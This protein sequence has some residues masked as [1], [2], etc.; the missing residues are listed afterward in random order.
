MARRKRRHW[1]VDKVILSLAS[2]LGSNESQRF[3]SITC[4][5]PCRTQLST[6]QLFERVLM[7]ALLS[8]TQMAT[9]MLHSPR[10]FLEARGDDHTKNMIDYAVERI[11]RGFRHSRTFLYISRGITVGIP[12]TVPPVGTELEFADLIAFMA[13]RQLY[14]VLVEKP[15]ELPTSA[16]G[17]ANWTIIRQDGTFVIKSATGVPDLQGVPLTAPRSTNE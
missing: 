8:T 13:R 6:E 10:F 12:V 11:G 9:G 4:L 1:E 14:R 17:T 2:F 7:I 15:V 16:I 3:I 5:P